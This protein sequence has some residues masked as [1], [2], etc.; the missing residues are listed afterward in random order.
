MALQ[1]ARRLL[2]TLRE[3]GARVPVLCQHLN[4]SRRLSTRSPLEGERLYPTHIPTNPL[5][6]T[7]LTLGA[8]AGALIS[9][10]RAD[11]VAT[12]GET[13]GYFALNRMRDGY[14]QMRI[15]RW[16][17]DTLVYLPR[18]VSEYLLRRVE[19]TGTSC[20]H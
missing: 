19:H 3:E 10:A 13:T 16:T 1:A 6:R 14:V 5:Q 11:L 15:F 9:P 8:A 20:S 2:P 7:L 12:L 17:C 4:A 18:R